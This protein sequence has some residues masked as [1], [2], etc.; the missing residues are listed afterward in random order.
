MSRALAIVGVALALAGQGVLL[1]RMSYLAG[2]EDGEMAGKLASGFAEGY[3]DGRTTAETLNRLLEEA[4][5]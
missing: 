4:R 3:L 2:Y 1:A 5:K